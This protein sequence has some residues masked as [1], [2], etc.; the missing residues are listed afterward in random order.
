[1]TLA[2]H[3]SYELES[4]SGCCNVRPQ[5]NESLKSGYIFKL[6]RLSNIEYK[7]REHT[8]I[9]NVRPTFNDSQKLS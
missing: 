6:F 8:L 3:L 9:S 2:T 4:Q 7:S 5:K 1:M